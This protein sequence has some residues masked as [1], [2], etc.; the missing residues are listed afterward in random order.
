[1]QN[2]D[3]EKG[4]EALLHSQSEADDEAMQQNAELQDRNS[5]DLASRLLPLLL[6][7]RFALT[8]S[9]SMSILELAVVMMRIVVFEAISGRPA[10]VGFSPWLSIESAVAS[11]PLFPA[12][13]L[14]ALALR[15]D[16]RSFGQRFMQKGRSIIRSGL[17]IDRACHVGRI[18]LGSRSSLSRRV[19]FGRAFL[20][21]LAGTVG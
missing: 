20:L 21:A 8:L 4:D 10:V 18:A 7:V 3:H 14:L 9:S 16:V 13:H 19:C 15:P 1:M 17:C 5:D 11:L 2:D 6:S 12:M